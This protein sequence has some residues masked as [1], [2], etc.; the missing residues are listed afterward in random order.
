METGDLSHGNGDGKAIAAAG[1]EEVERGLS[2]IEGKHARTSAATDAPNG[3]GPHDGTGAAPVRDPNAPQ[4]SAA[5]PRVDIS[6]GKARGDAPELDTSGYT[7]LAG[8]ETGTGTAS[9]AKGAVGGPGTDLRA[10]AQI[11]APAAPPARDDRPTDTDDPNVQHDTGVELVTAPG[12]P[13]KQTRPSTNLPLSDETGGPRLDQR[14]DEQFGTHAPLAPG[15]R[16]A[17]R[18]ADGP[19]VQHDTGV[20]ESRPAPGDTGKQARPT[21]NLSLSGETGGQPEEQSSGAAAQMEQRS[22]RPAD[23]GSG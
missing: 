12:D 14:T 18:P 22:E 3:S 11:T 13:R 20:L 8:K 19:N 1:R 2:K 6:A 7:G 10:N 17:A 15:D 5:A 4:A 23:A 9:A 16:P 21:T